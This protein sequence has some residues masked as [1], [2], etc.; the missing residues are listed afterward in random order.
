SS[1]ELL[2][3]CTSQLEGA[4]KTS[5][6]AREA[7]ALL[8]QRRSKVVAF[9]PQGGVAAA[10]LAVVAPDSNRAILL[11]TALVPTDA[12]DY[13]LWIIPPG[14]GAAPI[15][16]GLV[17]AGEGIALGN[18]DPGVLARGAVALA[19]SAEPKGGS[20]TGTPTQVVL[21][22]ALSG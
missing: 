15:P 22:A 7:I 2:R 9:A 1:A 10:A 20:R 11:S 5:G 21:V 16:A 19:V 6:L 8:E 13:E 12:R 3:Q 17:V 4:K 14:K 18:F